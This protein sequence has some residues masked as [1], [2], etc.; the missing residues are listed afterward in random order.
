MPI[1]SLESQY[2]TEVA[3]VNARQDAEF[4]FAHARG[5]LLK[6]RVILSIPLIKVV[7]AP[8]DRPRCRLYMILIEFANRLYGTA[9]LP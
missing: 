7:F 8:W 4:K 3:V 1:R 9:A 6:S 5:V 2:G